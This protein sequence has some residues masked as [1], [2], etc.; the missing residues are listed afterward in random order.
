M[1]ELLVLIALLI[2]SIGLPGSAVA[3]VKPCT[4]R[5]TSAATIE[6]VQATPA[7]YLGKCVR[8]RGILAGS[9]LYADRQATME[10]NDRTPDDRRPK[11]SI[12]VLKRNGSAPALV[13]ISGRLSDCGCAND[14]LA[15]YEAEHPGEIVMLSG[16][17]HTSME[18]YFDKPAVRILS[19]KRVA[20]L[21]EAEVPPG[22]RLLV[23]A[24]A[25]LPHRDEATNA[26]RAFLT[27]IATRDEATFRKFH[28]PEAQDVLDTEGSYVKGGEREWLTEAR[29]DF[30]KSASLR[31]VT[32]AILARA[33]PQMRILIEAAALED[34]RKNGSGA[35]QVTTCWCTAD[36][37]SGRWP[38]APTQADNLPG[39][40][41]FCVLVSNYVL[42]KKGTVPFA[43]APQNKV[44][45][46][47]P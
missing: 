5:E 36:D 7:D 9:R 15:G 31:L 23:E 44:G 20:R 40:P 33:R 16:Y 29:A 21:I 18:T 25:D 4:A 28:N 35:D 32:A 12:A 38:I 42:Y 22:K 11:R 46:A 3:A 30:A 41:Y 19:Q 39:R 6:Q 26:A 13:E 17:C 47:E 2:G 45:F 10:I 8:L 1:R 27:A 24:P 34:F 37:C 43:E 14:G